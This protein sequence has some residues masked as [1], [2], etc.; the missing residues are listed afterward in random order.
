MPSFDD[1][2]VYVDESGDHS[3]TSIDPQYP[4]FVLAFC[5]FDKEKYAEEVT[6]N[7]THLKFKYFGHDQVILHEREIRKEEA[8][9]SI[10]RREETRNEFHGDV[11]DIVREAPLTIFASVID[12]RRLKKEQDDPTNPYHLAMAFGLER[13]YRH[14]NGKGCEEGKLHVVFEERGDKEDRN[15]ELEFRRVLDEENNEVGVQL[16]FNIVF[17]NKQSN[18]AGLQLADLVARPIGRYIL[19]PGQ[20][21][22]AYDV[23]EEKLRR[24]PDGEV[25]GKGL[26]VFP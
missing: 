16:P 7:I 17:S 14:L 11:S 10:L 25:R 4:I 19:K 13:L 1:Y 5:L 26:K 8:A 22:R 9:F 20:R 2:I 6:T 3:L 12:K 21:N 15:L 24:G 23:I 18:A